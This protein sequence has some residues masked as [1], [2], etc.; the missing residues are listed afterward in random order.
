M[1]RPSSS[2]RARSSRPSPGSTI[3]VP[4]PLVEGMKNPPMPQSRRE[5][6]IRIIE[7]IVFSM[8]QGLSE[9]QRQNL[10]DAVRDAKSPSY[11]APLTLFMSKVDYG[12]ITDFRDAYQAVHAE[13]DA[14]KR[15]VSALEHTLPAGETT[16]LKL[17]SAAAENSATPKADFLGCLEGNLLETA[18]AKYKEM[19]ERE[20]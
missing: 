1:P 8:K 10:D 11:V 17:A 16:E 15:T 4:G 13:L 3:E 2:P 18:S 5:R 7:S 6:E 20:L 14:V 12:L 19:A 9:A